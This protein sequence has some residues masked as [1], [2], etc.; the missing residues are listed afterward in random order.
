MPKEHEVRN[1][2]VVGSS[3]TERTTALDTINGRPSSRRIFSRI[4]SRAGID[5]LF[6]A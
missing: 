2:E 1:P 6:R 5:A 3:P 4:G